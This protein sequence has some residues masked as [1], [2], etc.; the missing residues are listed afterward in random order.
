MF[1][2][3]LTDFTKVP[4]CGEV[5]AAAQFPHPADA[6]L[7]DVLVK[8]EDAK[9]VIWTYNDEVG[10]YGTGHYLVRAPGS[11]AED[12]F[13]LRMEAY[14]AFALTCSRRVYMQTAQKVA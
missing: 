8:L 5:K 6:H 10:G 4:Q 9:W 13:A 2:T 12:C 3:T 11:S 14:A 1:M 7:W